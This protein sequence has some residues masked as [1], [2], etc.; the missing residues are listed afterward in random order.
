MIVKGLQAPRNIKID[1]APSPRQYEMWKLLQPN[2]CPHCGGKIEVVEAGFDD[3]GKPKFAPQC[4]QC[5][6]RKLP[7]FILGGG[8]AGKLSLCQ[9]CQ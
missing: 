3:R 7:R 6:S 8:A 4:T 9:P 2:E 5:K 1:F